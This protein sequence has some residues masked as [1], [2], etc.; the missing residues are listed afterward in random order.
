MDIQ[1][2]YAE[3]GEG[4]PLILLHGNGEDASYF[5]HQLQHFSK[6][7]RVIAVETRWHGES[8]RGTAPFTI[9]QFAE[10]LHDFMMEHEIPKA[11]ILGF[12]DGGNI[13][14]IFAMRYPEMVERL[15]VNGANL[16]TDGTKPSFQIPIEQTY[17]ELLAAPNL[18]P[19]GQRKLALYGVMVNDP[20]IPT[21]DL[22]GIKAKTLVI[23]G[24][25]DV[26]EEAHTRLIYE[27]LPDAELQFI[28]G[29]H[30][31]AAEEPELFNQ[32]VE[33]FLMNG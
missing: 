21:E 1:L 2:N 33:R 28:E 23:A 17:R 10:D 32:A 24:T 14:L 13:A 6:C 16:T 20:N 25:D 7:F 22:A 9:R 31:I 18:S 15:I 26:I 30:F 19:R 27:N 12:S 8:P 29:T 4:F 11:H 5:V 3:K